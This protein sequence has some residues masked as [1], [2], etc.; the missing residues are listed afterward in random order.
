VLTSAGIV[1]ARQVCEPMAKTDSDAGRSPTRENPH[2]EQGTRMLWLGE[3]IVKQFKLPAPNQECI[4]TALQEEGWPSCIDD[5]LPPTPGVDSK[6]RLHDTIFRLNRGQRRRLIRFNG[7]GNGLA[8][9][10]E[11]APTG[12]ATDNRATTDRV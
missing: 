5:P 10:W 2:W 9:H 6:R 11:R 8:I 3:S 12:V 1:F 4:L 7:N